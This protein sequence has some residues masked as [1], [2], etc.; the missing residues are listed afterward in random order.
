MYIYHTT[1]DVWPYLNDEFRR[2]SKN[3]MKIGYT[4]WETNRLPD[5]W[6]TCINTEV[7]EVWCPSKYNKNVFEESGIKIPIKVAPHVFLKKPLFERGNIELYSLDGQIIS[8]K[9]DIY[10]FYTIGEFNARKGIDELINVFCTTFTRKDKVRL[11]IKTHYKNYS[12]TNKQSCIDKIN[13]IIK[14]YEN[15][16]EIHCFLDNMSETELLALH[17][18]GDCYI[19][20]TK[21][22]G[23]GMT[24]FDAMNYGKQ[25]I[26]TGYSGHMDFLG[27]DH[28]GLVKFKLDY[29]KNMKQFSENYSE[30]T[31]WA[32]PDLEHAAELMKGMIK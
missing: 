22:E 18:L 32:Y 5:K 9:E 2:E 16:P 30:K 11:L 13:D 28:N 1:P 8:Y 27:E 31:I 17:S 14:Q 3:K 15:P 19:S 24:I 7:D 26:A 10:T 6:I 12:A 23:F 25:I 4:V 20:L 21:S 29:V